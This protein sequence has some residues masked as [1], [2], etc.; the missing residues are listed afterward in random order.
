MCYWHLSEMLGNRYFMIPIRSEGDYCMRV[1][2]S[3]LSDTL[4]QSV[5]KVE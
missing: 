2:C 5:G 1:D 4:N 3:A